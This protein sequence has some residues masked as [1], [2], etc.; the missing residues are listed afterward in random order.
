[1]KDSEAY[2]PDGSDAPIRATPPL[3][4]DYAE[5]AVRLAI[6]AKDLAQED[7]REDVKLLHRTSDL[8]ERLANSRSVLST[9]NGR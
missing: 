6:I 8:L 4:G 1:M 3:S 5:L 7:R 2:E 9:E